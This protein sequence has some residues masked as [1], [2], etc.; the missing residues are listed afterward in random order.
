MFTT[1]QI[2]ISSATYPI[3]KPNWVVNDRIHQLQHV[4]CIIV[5]L[6]AI[7]MHFITANSEYALKMPEK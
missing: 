4:Y 1:L 3:S 7:P 5:A 2:A 6:E